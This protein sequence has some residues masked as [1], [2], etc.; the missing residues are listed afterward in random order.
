MTKRE[1]AIIEPYTG[2]CML[3]GEDMDLFYKY[4][5]EKMGQPIYTHEIPYLFD[6]IRKAA[7]PDFI[8]LCRTATE[9]E[10]W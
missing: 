4:I 7:E 8:E 1:C 2:M 5:S 9:G 10:P 3:T 6:S